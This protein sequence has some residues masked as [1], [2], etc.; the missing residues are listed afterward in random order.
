V[1]SFR[2]FRIHE[3][4]AGFESLQIDALSA[5]EVVIR[6]AWSDINYKD[7]LAAT[8]TGRILRR[9]PL[10]GGVDLSLH[11]WAGGAGHRLRSV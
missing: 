8:G 2:A 11:A 4:H 10:V 6:V 5:G 1:Q 7:A 9:F 3:D